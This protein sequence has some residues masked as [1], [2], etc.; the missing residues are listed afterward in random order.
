MYDTSELEPN[1][2]VEKAVL[3]LDS[4][5]P[6]NQFN[7]AIE[8]SF[9][10]LSKQTKQE[11]YLGSTSIHNTLE[12]DSILGS[13]S[14]TDLGQLIVYT[15]NTAKLSMGLV[16]YSTTPEDDRCKRSIEL[17]DLMMETV[18]KR[19]KRSVNDNEIDVNPKNLQEEENQKKKKNKKKKSKG[20]K[21]NKL[22]VRN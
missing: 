10:S 5:R 7:K 4:P 17:A 14:V 20:T 6:R 22:Q 16:L 18:L 9:Y 21:S 11:T 19:H 15:E 2:T 8:V 13:R 3:Q 12:L 1:E